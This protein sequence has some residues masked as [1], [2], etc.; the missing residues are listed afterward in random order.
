LIVTENGKVI[1]KIEPAN[2]AGTGTSATGGQSSANRIVRKVEP[3]YPPQAR[4]Q[5][6][7]G[8]VVLDVRIGSDG[9]VGNVDVVSGDPVLAGAAVS[10]VKQWVYAP[11]S[12]DG[13]EVDRQ[14]RI[15][16]RFTLS[17]G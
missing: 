14:T 15:T 2:A 12:P 17:P 11:F 6:I 8:P 10:A 4:A 5:G 3:E 9:R 13:K 1:Y 7:Q 16:F